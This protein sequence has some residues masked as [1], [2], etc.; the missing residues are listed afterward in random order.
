MNLFKISVLAVC[1]CQALECE[2]QQSIDSTLEL[3]T[4][5]ITASRLDNFTSGNKKQTLDSSLLSNYSIN[6]LADVLANQSQ[7]FIKSYGLGSLA[8]TSFRGAGASHTALLWNGFN[9]QSPMNGLV[10]MALVPSFFFNNVQLQYGGAGAL[11]GTG[12]V[13]G[14]IYLNNAGTFN[15][16]FSV[17][18]NLSHGSFADDQQQVGIEVSKKRFVS[19]VKLFNHNAKNNFPFINTAQFGKPEQQQ[20]NAALKQQGF[21]QENY[22]KINARQLLTTRFWYQFND[23]DIPPSMTTNISVANQK[24][25]FY[26]TAAEWKRTG[27]KLSTLVR[28]AYFEDN[29]WYNDSSVNLA[30]K[31]KTKVFIAEAEN[32]FSITKYD[33]LNLGVNN[34]LSKATSKD[35][36]NDPTQNRFALFM[37][38]KI[39]TKNNKW[40]G[41]VSARQEMVNNKPAPFTSSIGTTA[42]ILRHFYINA[43]AARHYRLPTFNDLYWPQGGNPNLKP[44]QGWSEEVGISYKQSYYKTTWDGNA[45]VFNRNINDWIIWLPNRYGIW[46]PDNVQQVW[47]RGVEYKLKW[48]VELKKLKIQLSGLYNYVL[49][50]NEKTTA[51]NATSLGKQLIYVPVQNAQGNIIISY[52]GTSF[53]YTQVYTGYRYTI[54]DNTEFLN[55][56]TIGNLNVSHTFLLQS[57][58]I[59][60]YAQLNNIWN[61]TYQVM[62]YY[63]M[64]LANYQFGL[65][66]NYNQPNKNNTNK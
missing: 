29:L 60:I 58:R 2:A 1:V 3:R 21:L 45:T 64:P 40:D 14:T 16:G 30:S 19:S 24:D 36:K 65:T 63:A 6:N 32:R 10:D 52:K 51:S 49:S 4:V 9:I 54:S 27:N 35:Y 50:T 62:A 20:S 26:R 8:T 37:N 38:Y 66:L 55:P 12:A 42:N 57:F 59:K 44:E 61:E 23:R 48:N 39:H 28:A 53:M 5:E 18:S 46:S 47:S 17:F 43:N 41:V 25:E 15:K 22:F 33:L 7:V 34:T 31:S 13:G 11:W 56:Y